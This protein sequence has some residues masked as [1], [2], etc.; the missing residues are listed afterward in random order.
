MSNKCCL[1]TTKVCLDSSIDTT[2]KP[3]SSVKAFQVLAV[4]YLLLDEDA[5]RCSNRVAKR[6]SRNRPTQH[7]C[8]FDDYQLPCCGVPC[9]RPIARH[10]EKPKWA[11]CGL[12]VRS[13]HLLARCPVHCRSRSLVGLAVPTQPISSLRRRTRTKCVW[14]HNCRLWATLHVELCT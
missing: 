3:G 8:S 12:T 4:R 6:M 1:V 11:W 13:R 2:V 14:Q 10:D 5:E 7:G 9:E